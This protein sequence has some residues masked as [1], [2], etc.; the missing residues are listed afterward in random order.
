MKFKNKT[1]SQLAEIIC[2]NQPNA[3]KYFPYR[4]SSLITNFFSDAETEYCHDGSTRNLW[5][6]NTLTEILNLPS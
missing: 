1:I 6:D 2:G 5:V 3:R 4:S